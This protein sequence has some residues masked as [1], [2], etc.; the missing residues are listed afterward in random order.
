[1]SRNALFSYPEWVLYHSFNSIKHCVCVILEKTSLKFLPKGAF[2]IQLFFLQLNSNI[3]K[4]SYEVY[5]IYRYISAYTSFVN[6]M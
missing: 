1:M 2:K 3:R 6:A 5:R 4:M